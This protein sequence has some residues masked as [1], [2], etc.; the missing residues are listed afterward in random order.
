MKRL[1]ISIACGVFLTA[2]GLPPA[3]PHKLERFSIRQRRG[4]ESR[5]VRLDIWRPADSRGP[6][7]LLLF[8]PGLGNPPASY[9]SQLEDLASHGYVVAALEHEGDSLDS[10]ESRARLWGQDLLEAKKAV[11]ESSLRG[12]IDADRVGVFGHSHGG[13]SAAAACLLDSAI[14]A[15]LNQ[16]GRY[17]DVRLQRPYWPIA[18][19]EFAGAFALLD[20][21]DPGFSD[22]DFRSMGATRG[23]Y[24][25]ARL[26]PGKSALESFRA[27]RGGAY[28]ITL[29]DAGMQHTAFTDIPWSQAGTDAERT[30]Y[31]RYL[32]RIREATREFFDFTLRQGGT[33]PACGEVKR[34]IFVQCF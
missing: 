8:S 23:G 11:L 30:R 1:L 7:S 34:D 18:G 5:A 31:A 16:D 20:W 25:A 10:A 15:C 32:N 26:A 3:G 22:A 21:F 24:A 28:R 4:P 12:I 2:Q 13:R 17:D 27:P 14:R 29:L 9:L 33:K 19:R 6:F